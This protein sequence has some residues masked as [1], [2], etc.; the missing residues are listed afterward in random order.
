MTLTCPLSTTTSL[1]LQCHSLS[2]ICSSRLSPILSAPPPLHR[3]LARPFCFSIRGRT[4]PSTPPTA[5]AGKGQALGCF[6][7]PSFDPHTCD[8]VLFIQ[9]RYPPSHTP[10]LTPDIMETVHHQPG[11]TYWSDHGVHGNGHSIRSALFGD[12][13]SPYTVLPPIHIPPVILSH[14]HVHPTINPIHTPITPSTV[15][16]QQIPPIQTAW[17]GQKS[18]FHTPVE[19]QHTLT[20]SP[21]ASPGERLPA[22]RLARHNHDDDYEYEGKEEEAEGEDELPVIVTATPRSA[23]RKGVKRKM[24]YQRVRTGCLTCRLRRVKCGEE[25]PICQRCGM[26]GWNVSHERSR[27]S[28]CEKD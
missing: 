19:T 28:C 9:L 3:R 21:S 2:P 5:V 1:S 12:H 23:G 15:S 22:V 11:R 27:R 13:H 17:S 20:P 8:L 6:S 25:K 10:T 24:K 26:A 16:N 7:D 18:I 14:H 4:T